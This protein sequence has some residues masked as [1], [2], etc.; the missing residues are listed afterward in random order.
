MIDLSLFDLFIPGLLIICILY[1]YR[2]FLHNLLVLYLFFLLV[3]HLSI[4]IALFIFMCYFLLLYC[5][6]PFS[7]I[8]LFERGRIWPQVTRVLTGVPRADNTGVKGKG[9]GKW[10][11]PGT[12]SWGDTCCWLTCGRPGNEALL[13]HLHFFP[14]ISTRVFLISFL[15][16]WHL[17]PTEASFFSS[18]SS[19]YFFLSSSFSF[20]SLF[21]YFLFYLFFI[22]ISFFYFFLLFFYSF[23]SIFFIYFFH[24]SFYFASIFFLFLHL[25]LSFS[26]LFFFISQRA[27]FSIFFS[28]PF[29]NVQLSSTSSVS[30]VCLFIS[31][32]SLHSSLPLT[33]SYM[34][35]TISLPFCIAMIFLH[36]LVSPLYT[37]QP[38]F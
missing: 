28:L 29:F 37:N 3:L 20:F 24:F 14:G 21:Y 6:L 32:F 9:G 27:H 38:F 35:Q 34:Q 36:I 7:Q 17:F 8:K 18:I 10:E 26:S 22:F 11:W 1:F 12:K 15:L 5:F 13:P 19:F 16:N 30:F 25:S 33:F 2:Y 23:L 4:F 31:A